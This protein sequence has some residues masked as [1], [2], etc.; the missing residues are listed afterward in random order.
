MTVRPPTRAPVACC[1]SWLR[2]MRPAGAAGA[3]AP[4]VIGCERPSLRRRR[5]GPRIRR[6]ANPPRCRLRRRARCATCG[7]CTVASPTA[8]II[9]STAPAAT[10]RASAGESSPGPVGRPGAGRH[11]GGLALR[12]RC[13]AGG[14]RDHGLA[15]VRGRLLGQLSRL[16]DRRRASARVVGLDV[17]VGC[18]AHGAGQ[19]VERVSNLWKAIQDRTAGPTLEIGVN[20][21]Y[22]RH[23]RHVRRVC[24]RF[25]IRSVGPPEKPAAGCGG[26]GCAAGGAARRP[27]LLRLRP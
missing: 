23:V 17:G 18:T 1:F 9:L 21:G 7:W 11:A 20:V 13:D 5:S 2:P 4:L 27:V 10:L 19:A 25:R 15:T 6:R 24:S 14:I 16:I 12:D 22:V 3:S 8:S 26:S